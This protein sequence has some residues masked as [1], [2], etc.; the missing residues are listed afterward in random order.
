MRL[1]LLACFGLILLA[2]LGSC[3]KEETNAEFLERLRTSETQG[4]AEGVAEK[5]ALSVDE[6]KAICSCGFNKLID[7][8]NVETLKAAEKSRDKTLLQEKLTPLM[9]DCIVEEV[10]KAKAPSAKLQKARATPTN[11]PDLTTDA[12]ARNK[13]IHELRT[14]HMADCKKQITQNPDM[15]EADGHAICEC[16]ME[17]IIERGDLNAMRD[18]DVR[19]DFQT[20]MGL[21]SPFLNQ[22]VDQVYGE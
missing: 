9:Q 21:L 15:L 1:F 11:L 19:K 6:A 10:D 17:A 2:L 7:S 4:C 20:L 3:A 18:A 13:Y 12:D 22:C 14:K 8:M 5:A 16:G